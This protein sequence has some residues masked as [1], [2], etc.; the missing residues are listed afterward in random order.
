MYIYIYLG[1]PQCGQT[2]F[3]PLMLSE[4]GH[5]CITSTMQHIVIN[6][7]ILAVVAILGVVCNI[8][9]SRKHD[10]PAN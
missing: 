9:I 5:D 2:P 1:G 3:S 10:G 8:M 7:S 6:I 4:R